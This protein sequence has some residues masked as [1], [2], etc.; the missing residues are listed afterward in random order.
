MQLFPSTVVLSWLRDILDNWRESLFHSVIVEVV[1]KEET[2]TDDN[3]CYFKPII[4]DRMVYTL[5]YVPAVS[6]FFPTVL[7]PFAEFF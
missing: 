3:S 4:I 6:L 1:I 5:M 2:V 7:A